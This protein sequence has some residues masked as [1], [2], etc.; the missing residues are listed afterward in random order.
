MYYTATQIAKKLGIS[1]SYL[2]YLKE[3]NAVEMEVA[4]NGRV[5]WSK[6]VYQRLKEY[7]NQNRE[8]QDDTPPEPE[9]KTVRI[10]NRRYLGNNISYWSLLE[11]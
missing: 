7:L 3:N 11:M 5:R 9:Y 6:D 4:E 1:R 2:Y 8:T 10:N